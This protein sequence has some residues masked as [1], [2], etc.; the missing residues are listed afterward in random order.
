MNVW[1]NNHTRHEK[2]SLGTTGMP[3]ILPSFSPLPACLGA[4]EVDVVAVVEAWK[5]RAGGLLAVV[6]VPGGSRRRGPSASAAVSSQVQVTVETAVASGIPASAASHAVAQSKSSATFSTKTVA[7]VSVVATML[8]ARGSLWRCGQ[9]WGVRTAARSGSTAGGHCP[10]AL[11]RCLPQVSLLLGPACAG[12]R[13]A[14]GTQ[15]VEA[16]QLWQPRATVSWQLRRQRASAR[17]TGSGPRSSARAPQRPSSLPCG[18]SVRRVSTNTA[19]SS[20]SPPQQT[21]NNRTTRAQRPR[22]N[23]AKPQHTRACYGGA[24]G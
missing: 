15:T 23:H 21:H 24:G 22:N 12:T 20:G 3:Q 14:T 17:A 1:H 6:G 10:A 11:S 4:H 2:S 13:A 16:V 19:P 18:S 5:A 7:S 9:G 8:A